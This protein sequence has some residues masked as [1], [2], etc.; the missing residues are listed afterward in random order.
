MKKKSITKKLGLEKL[1][2]TKLT[3]PRVIMGGSEHC[4]LTDPP[5]PEPSGAF[6]CTL[7]VTDPK[8]NGGTNRPTQG[9]FGL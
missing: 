9:C 8:N 1:E 5:K 4:P 3:N 7:T 6:T 2:I